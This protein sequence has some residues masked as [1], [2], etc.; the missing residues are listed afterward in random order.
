MFPGEPATDHVNVCVL[1]PEGR[2]WPNSDGRI[3]RPSGRGG[4]Q[5]SEVFGL[6]R[7]PNLCALFG[8]AI[9]PALLPIV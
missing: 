8:A 9:D 4:S 1:K 3:P 2:D 5:S 6:D 7:L